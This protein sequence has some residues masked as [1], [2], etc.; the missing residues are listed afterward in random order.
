M[1]NFNLDFFV[2]KVINIKMVFTT[3]FLKY[4]NRIY[5]F[6]IYFEF[7]FYFAFLVHYVHYEVIL[8]IIVIN[9]LQFTQK[10]FHTLKTDLLNLIFNIIMVF[11]Q[12]P[13]FQ[14]LTSN[15]IVF[16]IK[17]FNLIFIFKFNLNFKFIFFNVIQEREVVNYYKFHLKTPQS[18]LHFLKFITDSVIFEVNQKFIIIIGLFIIF[19]IIINTII[20]VIMVIMVVIIANYRSDLNFVIFAANLM[21]FVLHI[22]AEVAS[23]AI[24]KVIN[25]VVVEIIIVKDL[26]KVDLYTK[27]FTQTIIKAAIISNKDYSKIISFC[28]LFIFIIF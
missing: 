13:L 24:I 15:T 22:I 5:F 4:F 28:K 16:L 20:D 11:D 21:I 19:I 12:Y 6:L 3:I 25:L 23:I 17:R 1:I 10:Y 26:L 2:A 27:I 7:A 8:F 9:Y 14:L 18:Y